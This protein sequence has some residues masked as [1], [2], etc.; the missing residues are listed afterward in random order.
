MTVSLVEIFGKK[1][2]YTV[3]AN[4]EMIATGMR[5][6]IPSFFYCFASSA[7]L[8]KTL[9]KESTGTQS[10][11]SGLVTSLVLLLV[12]LW[13]ALLFYSLQTS[14]LGVVT[15]VNLQGGLRRFRDTPGMWQLSKL[16]TV[17]W[18]ATICC[19]PR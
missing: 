2:G 15:I 9:L 7:A 16:D 6:L 14:I 4:H 8:S 3:C 10:Q 11:V 18:W 13:I 17:V 1:H 19:P 5:N 12:L